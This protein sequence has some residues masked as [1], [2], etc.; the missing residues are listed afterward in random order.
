MLRAGA[1]VLAAIGL[2]VSAAVLSAAPPRRVAVAA[3][4]DL[5]F[6]L[7]AVVADYER[8]HP[9]VD[10]AVT[11]GSSG[12][13]SAQIANG[14]PF[15]LFLSADRS[16]PQRL[17][18]Q[19]RAVPGTEFRYAVGRIVVWVPARWA[20]DLEAEGLKALASPRVAHV[21][22]ANPEHAPYGRAAL[23]ALEQAGLLEAI[24][25]KLVYGE[26]VGQALQFVQSGAA[27]AGI[28]ALSLALAPA[29]RAAGRYWVVPP[30][31]YPEMAQEGVVL[32]SAREDA[33]RALRRFLM[34]AQARATL[35]R[36][37]FSLPER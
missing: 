35:K 15:D 28:V 7:D 36:F 29:A 21:S 18:E 2:V 31:W 24:R 12:V 22:I 25:P 9:D 34:S 33:A 14:A 10:V 17:L 20:F 6:A 3:A 37:G 23:A 26:N 4:S 8:S 27:D 19:G 5:R 13:L 30:D 11:Y 32:K 16:Y 1:A